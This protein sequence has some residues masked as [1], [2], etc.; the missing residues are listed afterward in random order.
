MFKIVHHDEAFFAVNKPTG[1]LS[2]PGRGPDKQDCVYH[3]VLD[4]FPDALVVHRLDMETS[5]LMLFARTPEAQRNISMQFEK[6]EIHKTYVAIVEGMLEPAAGMIDSPMRKDMEHRLPPK[7]IIDFEQ[8]KKAIT[9]WKVLERE[10]NTTRVELY[11]Q[12]GRS[13]QLRVHMLALGHPIIGDPIYGTRADRLMLHAET[14][15][16]KHPASGEA[17]RLECPAPF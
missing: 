15:E 16:L 11:P 17:I 8:G 14:L 12:T 6:R 13:H 9:K 4:Q 5:G 2:V 7:H 10:K 3:R 1:L